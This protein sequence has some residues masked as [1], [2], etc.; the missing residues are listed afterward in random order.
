MKNFDIFKV[1]SLFLFRMQIKSRP[2]RTRDDVTPMFFSLAGFIPLQ[3]RCEYEVSRQENA[4][5]IFDPR[6]LRST[7]NA[8][9]LDEKFEAFR[10]LNCE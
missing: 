5:G 3:G 10:M 6:A 4:L 2:H 1:K 7:K 9:K 8:R